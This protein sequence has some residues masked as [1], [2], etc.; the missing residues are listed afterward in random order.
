MAY[1]LLGLL[2]INMPLLNGEGKNAFVRLQEELLRSSD[3]ESILTWCSL[4]EQR[5]AFGLSPH[6][7]DHKND[8]KY[9][10]QLFADSPFRFATC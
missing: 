10:P 1:C 9:H 3:E 8:E 6:G 7:R 2:K 4:N 5:D